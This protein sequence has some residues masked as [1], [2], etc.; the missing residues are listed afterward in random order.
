MFASAG[1]FFDAGGLLEIKSKCWSLQ[2]NAV[3]LDLN[4]EMC[5][6]YP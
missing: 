6:K 1:D 4:I 3:D 5:I 2:L